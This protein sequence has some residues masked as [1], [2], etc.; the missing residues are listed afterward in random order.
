MAT[1]E[2][3]R[4]PGKDHSGP[5]GH[6]TVLP[7]QGTLDGFARNSRSTD[8]V[9]LHSLDAGMTLSVRTLNSRYRF[10][11]LDGEQL[12]VLVTGGSRFPDPTEVRVEGSTTGGS[13]LIVGWIG[14]GL[15]L[16]LTLGNRRIT[17]SIVQSVTFD[18]V[19]NDVAADHW[20]VSSA[21]WMRWLC[22]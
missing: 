2:S 1:F 14:V 21:A 11:V 19:P 5:S 6:A 3:N 9:E 4:D 8:G 18:G 15:R 16:E 7:I 13:T 22:A 12:R 17:T 20:S 10:V